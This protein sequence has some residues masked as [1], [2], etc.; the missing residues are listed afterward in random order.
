M[1]GCS[2]WQLNKIGFRELFSLRS[3]SLW[4]FD[5]EQERHPENDGLD[6]DYLARRQTCMLRQQHLLQQPTDT[7]SA[8]ATQASHTIDFER[9]VTLIARNE[10][11]KK[12]TR[13]SGQPIPRREFAWLQCLVHPVYA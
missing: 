6:S 10:V 8:C 5:S 12:R 4:R 7:Y 11:G 3:R 9:Y 13:L 2:E 1:L